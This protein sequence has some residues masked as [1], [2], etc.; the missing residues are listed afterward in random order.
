M[1]EK[2]SLEQFQQ[3]RDQLTQ[4]YKQIEDNYEAHENDKNY[5]MDL[6]IKEYLK[7]Q[8]SLLNH[9]LSDIPFEAWKNFIIASD[10]THAVDFSKTKANI[11]FNIVEYYGNGNFKG[12]NVRNLDK[13]YS[14]SPNDFDEQTIQMNSKLFL[15]D[16]FS[17][18][19]KEK[20]YKHTL[21]IA[22]LASLSSKQL[23]EIKQK[24]FIKHMNYRE[25]DVMETIGIDKIV[26]LYQYSPE[27]YDAVND[28]VNKIM[29]VHRDKNA[30][31][32]D[33]PTY[34]E[35]LQQVKSADVSE[36]K[37]ICFDYAR[38]Q[39]T[40]SSMYINQ[41]GY[42]EAF[43]R[44]NSDIF[45]VNANIPDEVKQRYFHRYL[46]LQDLLDYPDVFGNISV[47]YFMES[48]THIS[49][50]IRDN[51]GMGKFQELVQKHPDLFTHISQERD[52]YTLSKFLQTGKDLDSTFDNAVKKYFLNY[53]MPEQFRIESDGQI[54]YNVPDWLSSMNFKFVDEIDSLNDLMQYNES[55]AVLDKNQ[56]IVLDALGIDNI[57]RFEQETGFFSHNEWR[58][59]EGMFSAFAYFFQK[60]KPN[61]LVKEG[62]DF[63]NGSLSYEDFLNQLANCLNNMRKNNIFID[64]PS[65]DWVQG[66]FRECHPEIFMNLNAP[67]EL[68]DAFYKNKLNPKFLYN[69]KEYIQYLKNQDLSSCFENRQI[70]V[71]GSNALNH[72][73]NLYKF[74]GSKTDFNGAMNFITEY[75]DILDIVF[76]GK[77]EE[78]YQYKPKFTIDDNI[79][80][81]K[82]RI[83]ETL[84]KLILEKGKA[85]PKHIPKD[86]IEQYP[87]IF[88]DKNAP[89]ELQEAF[90]N[91]TISAELV[92][93]NP[94]Y[95]KYLK[96]I[97]L[98]VLFKYMP[99]KD[100]INMQVNLISGIK[101]IFG[102]DEAFDI[103][104]LYGKYIEKVFE[105]NKLE[106][107]KF[108]QNFSKADLLDEMDKAILQ[109]IIDGKMKYDEKIPIHF[110]KNNP[111]LFLGENVSQDIKDKFYNRQFT[112][113]DFNDNPKL[114]DI[115]DKT[116]IT[117]GFSENMSW[118]IPLFNNSEN[119][120]IANY[121]RMKLILAYSRI[122]DTD[123]QDIFKDYVMEDETDIDLEK[124]EY[125]SKAF[126]RLSETNS[127]EMFKFRKELARQLLK[128]EDP[129]EKLNKVE[130]V[131]IKNNIPTVGKIYSCFEILHPDFQGFDFEKS[132]MVSPVLKNVT[133]RSKKIIVFSDLIKCAFGSNNRSINAYLKNID[134]GSGLYEKIKN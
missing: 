87:S 63:K 122:N 96:N 105:D 71:E 92:L 20:Y 91:R 35:F 127:I 90:Y 128:T 76:D 37:D 24:D 95:I 99:V 14:L 25:Y 60:H 72:N 75:S 134:F 132:S 40:N 69:H 27:K 85:Y 15:N 94:S 42:S 9:D 7:L 55:V 84:R 68:K 98:E 67:A 79:D 89:Q 26:Q 83:N 121:N 47:D 86:L 103:M 74:I 23:E 3:I 1:N 13:I 6:S 44:E 78:G 57:K 110:K 70:K 11:D 2:M 131:F 64:F 30:F 100:V 17:N 32:K 117:C 22:D 82:N 124:T 133:T 28:A 53:G 29:N 46:T 31:G 111:T 45:L 88:L 104:L 61:D 120:K 119:S 129:L 39:I 48:S 16:A 18:E 118:I 49:Q 59:S 113:N 126:A 10:E 36:L 116:N 112:I 77:D 106:Q 50:F 66:K 93:S 19:F 109:N 5:D 8:S 97:D 38:K 102:S 54:T 130:D 73:E 123:L 62:I 101:Q 80:K 56:R 21:S 107:F 115:F 12:C 51:Y 33:L 34:E 43:I 114:F 81:I 41:N 108:N 4:L 125:I 58:W 52:F 65:Y